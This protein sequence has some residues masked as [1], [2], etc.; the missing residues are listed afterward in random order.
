M[1]L[2]LLYL[3]PLTFVWLA[4]ESDTRRLQHYAVHG[5]DVS[6]YQ[7]RVDW[8]LV[9]EQ[10]IDFAFV[11][12]TEGLFYRDSFFCENWAAMQD[13][14]IKRGAYHFFRPTLSPQLQAD[15]FLRTVEMQAG[16]L[17]PVLDVEV[18]DG[19]S[20]VQ[21]ITRMRTWLYLVEIHYGIRPI[22][23]T[24][25]KFYNR[26][27]AGHFSDYPVWIAR[28]NWRR[29]TLACGSDWE[30]WQ[31]GQKGRLAGISGPVDFNVFHGDLTERDQYCLQANTVLSDEQQLAAD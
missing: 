6:H 23:Y 30:F 20:N 3:I 31:Y 14:G 2:R 5:I 8:P 10:G 22:I 13:A 21:L 25:L 26:Y 15:N 7:H 16:D 12:A 19:V 4:C 1:K 28:Y 27:L 17:A 9:A 24:H 18:L 29:P 11:K